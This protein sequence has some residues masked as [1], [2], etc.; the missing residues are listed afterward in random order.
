VVGDPALR[1]AEDGHQFRHV[2]LALV[3]QELNDLH[4]GQIGQA[5][6]NLA[7]IS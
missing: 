3:Q 1:L 7:V 6:K 5:M 2:L 4:A